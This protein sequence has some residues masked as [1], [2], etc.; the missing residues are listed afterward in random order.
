[1]NTNNEDKGF[2][3]QLYMRAERKAKE[4]ADLLHER[5]RIEMK[6]ERTREY[7]EKLNSFLKAEGEKP[8]SI[9]ATPHLGSVVGKPGN[10]SKAFPIRKMKWEGMSI[11]QIV[12][13]ILNASPAT[14][15]HPKDVASGIYEIESDSDLQLVM[16]NTRSAMQR[17]AREGLWER[18]GRAQFRAKATEKQ[19]ELA[20][21]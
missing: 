18:T 12:E 2:L 21:T 10:R 13:S 7:I 11:N 9:K 6:I 8:V 1:M 3:L 19:G 17:G 4:Y 16:R 14:S 20:K 15:F 5:Q